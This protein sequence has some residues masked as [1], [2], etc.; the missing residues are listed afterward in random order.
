LVASA[1]VALLLVTSLL[2]V[3][4]TQQASQAHTHSSALTSSSIDTSASMLAATEALKKLQSEV[5]QEIDQ[6]VAKEDFDRA[7]GR[8]DYFRR[9]VILSQLEQEWEEEL[10]LLEQRYTQH[11]AT[12][13][14]RYLEQFDRAIEQRNFIIARQ[15]LE[16]I[17]AV[18]PSAMR[19]QL[20]FIRS[21]LNAAE[22]GGGG[23][24][25]E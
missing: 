24:E 14:N 19:D 18:I 2:I 22:Q 1:V 9:Q 21:K 8:Y 5:E 10:I 4:Q 6:H 17:T 3:Y 16:K 23:N 13:F 11:Q 7:R 20:E 15:M 12:V 25:E